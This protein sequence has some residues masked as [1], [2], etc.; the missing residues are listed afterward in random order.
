MPGGVC[1]CARIPMERRRKLTI[2]RLRS[3]LY[4][5]SFL[6]EIKGNGLAD[7]AGIF[8]AIGHT[9]AD[10]VSIDQFNGLLSRSVLF[11]DCVCVW[12]GGG[13]WRVFSVAPVANYLQTSPAEWITSTSFLPPN[14]QPSIL[15]TRRAALSVV[16]Y[17]AV[18]NKVKQLH[19][20][21]QASQVHPIKRQRRIGKKK[22]KWRRFI[23]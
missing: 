9:L 19:Q 12:G 16:K 7:R 10:V 5:A 1:A 4:F 20:S 23:S 15:Q 3:F 21:L 8:A 14:V 6:A 11:F 18:V 13:S 17:E 2:D 22:M